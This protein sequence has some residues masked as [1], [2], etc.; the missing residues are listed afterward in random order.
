M[1]IND[2]WKK[3]EIVTE[4]EGVSECMWKKENVNIYNFGALREAWRKRIIAPLALTHMNLEGST[5]LKPLPGIK[6]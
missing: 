3:G 6:N 4:G 1:K 2:K 5:L